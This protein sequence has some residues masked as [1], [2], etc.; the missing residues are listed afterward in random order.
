M[1]TE[2][3][4]A[5][6]AYAARGWHVFPLLPNTKRPACPRHPAARC[7]RSDP[8]CRHGH[9]GWEQRATT[10]TRR[11][12]QAWSNH[13]YGIGIATGPSHLLGLDLDAAKPTEPV[14]PT[15]QGTDIHH[16]RDV[17]AR[18][19][20]QLNVTLPATYTVATPSGGRHLYYAMPTGVRL[21]NTAGRLGWLIDTR[22]HG[23]FLAAP[24]TRIGDHAYWVVDDRPPVPL[25]EWLTAL[26]TGP[27]APPP[28]PARRSRPVDRPYDPSR[29]SA[30]AAAAVVAETAMVRQAQPGQRN[31]ALFCAAVA[32]GQ[33][34]A[35]QALDQGEARAALLDAANGHMAA[36]AFT[37][38][39]ADATIT[40]GFTRG[41][42]RPRTPTRRTAA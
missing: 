17:L 20:D 33:L 29:T 22:G 8:F 12:R 41:A 37:A 24:P 5:A 31:H 39:Q 27:E 35:G 36:R 40:S 7:D 30:Y 28:T 21:G 4:E 14:P 10:S 11:I 2:L 9:A 25:P 16:G 42:S 23:G 32:L 3:L 19:L 18:L 38:G 6:L 15:W 26:L 13:P 34:V 1:N